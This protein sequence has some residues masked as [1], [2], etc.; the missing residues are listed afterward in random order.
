MFKKILVWV[1]R[2]ILKIALNK[3]SRILCIEIKISKSQN[4]HP[5]EKLETRNKFENDLNSNSRN[6]RNARVI[7]VESWGG[8]EIVED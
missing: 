5:L 8:L 7:K 3:N 1:K 6:E 4:S 2:Q